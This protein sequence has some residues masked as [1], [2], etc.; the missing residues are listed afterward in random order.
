[1]HRYGPEVRLDDPAF[2][3]PTAEIYGKVRIAKGASVWPFAVIRAEGHEI[4]IGPYSNIQDFVVLHIGMQC[5]T[6]IGAYCSITHHATIH[7]AALGD[8]C[9]VGVN[10]T[11]MDGCVVG[12]NCI[13]AGGAFLKEGTVIPDNSVVMGTPGRVTR[14]RNNW[15]ANRINALVYHRNAVAYARGDHRAWHGPDFDDFVKTEL[16]RLGAEFAALEP[17]ARRAA[18]ED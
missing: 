2:I 8:N 7:A 5:G 15:I 14:S 3:H 16:E 9:L 17:E 6:R 10:A 4:E 11:L 12:D 1:V 18:G 13:I